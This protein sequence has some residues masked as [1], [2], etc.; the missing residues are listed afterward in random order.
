[1]TTTQERRMLM[2]I[3]LCG[4]NEV[5]LQKK[6]TSCHFIQIGAHFSTTFAVFNN[7][8]IGKAKYY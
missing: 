1:M 3:F 2:I 5:Y 7:D 4:I 8:K 6:N